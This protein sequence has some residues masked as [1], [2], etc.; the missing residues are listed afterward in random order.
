MKPSPWKW[1]KALDAYS[2][3]CDSTAEYLS[4]CEYAYGKAHHCRQSETGDYEFCETNGYG[5]AER[6][7]RDGWPEGAEQAAKMQARLVFAVAEA[8]VAE[9]HVTYY[10]V[11][12]EEPDVGRYLAGEPENMLDFRLEDVPAFGRVAQVVFDGCVSAGVKAKHLMQAAV[13]VGA[14]IDSLE[15]SGIRCEF[16][17]RYRHRT[18]CNND[19]GSI[20]ACELEHWVKRANHPLDLAK[21]VAAMH[22]SAF[23]RVAFRW[24]ECLNGIN[25]GYGSV[26][27]SKRKVEPGSVAIE[28]AGLTP[29][30]GDEQKI[31][32]WMTAQRE[33]LLA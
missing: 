17:V 7:L 24:I 27:T 13:I 31:D 10:D 12:G 5:A 14:L 2:L 1:D 22:P 8:N 33:R 19:A 29:L 20:V 4:A 25:G 23:R 15:L 6:L 18:V 16:V 21:V 28:M 9:R 3:S 32:A 11:A 26:D 30:L